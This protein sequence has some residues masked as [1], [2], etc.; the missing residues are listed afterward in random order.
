MTFCGRICYDCV[1]INQLSVA[2]RNA[3]LATSTIISLRI[4]AIIRLRLRRAERYHDKFGD[5]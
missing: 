3:E 5:K 1:T 2:Q 4:P